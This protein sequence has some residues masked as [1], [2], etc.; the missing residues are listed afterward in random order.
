MMQRFSGAALQN[1]TLVLHQRTF[2]VARCNVAKFNVAKFNAL[3]GYS[4][5]PQTVP[6]S[7]IAVSKEQNWDCSSNFVKVPVEMVACQDLSATA[8]LLWVILANQAGFR[9]ISKAQ[10][11]AVLGVH[12]ATRLRLLKE[13]RELGLVKGEEHHLIL[14]NPIPI[15]RG[16]K[17][18]RIEAE[19][20]LAQT[21]LRDE[22][23]NEPEKPKEPKEKPDY[24]RH[25]TE[26]WNSYRPKDYSK[27]I[28]L[29]AGLLQAI[30]AHIKALKIEAHDYKAFFSVIKAGIERSQF[31]SKE[32]SSKTLQS[33]VGFG[34]PTSKK[35]NNVFALYNDGLEAPIAKPLTEVER[36]DK[37]VLPAKCRKLIDDYDE[38]QYYYYEC[39]FKPNCPTD[40]AAQFLTEKEEALVEAGLNPAQFRVLHHSADRVP[41]PTN[42]PTPTK[43]R[44]NFWSYRNEN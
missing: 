10:L 33:I 30:D 41:W 37:L 39:Y 29:S 13:L 12:R 36:Q 7:L 9:S 42:T 44:E 32:N 28:K 14:V 8:K 2:R 1:S 26:A 35:F 23:G 21:I 18:K 34:A 19:K 27:V 38:A 22:P 20:T 11:D 25:A 6:M 15:L 43:P 3:S 4:G 5:T 40:I 31:W 24:F 16:L 17:K